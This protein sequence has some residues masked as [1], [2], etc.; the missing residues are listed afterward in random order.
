M[1]LVQAVQSFLTNPVVVTIWVVLVVA[2]LATLAWD[3]RTN[4][5]K[6]VSLMKFVWGLTVFFSGPIALAAYWYS[7]RSQISHDSFWRGGWR[8]TAHCFSGCGIGEVVGILLFSTVFA[9]MG[10]AALALG[11][12]VLAY[13]GGTVLNVGPLMQEGVGF[14]EAIVDTFYSETTSITVME[15]AAIGTD[16][17]VAGEAGITSLLFWMGMA[18]SLSVG[19]LV[20]YPVNVLL[21]SR[22]V[23]GGMQDPTERRSFFADTGKN[24]TQ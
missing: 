9:F 24:D 13:L 22:G 19:F 20:S 5:V 11:T 10:T 4:N 18:L 8:S 23:K 6:M 16:L 21:V 7:G 15:V 17:L 1:A 14:R 3:I 12:F 2:S